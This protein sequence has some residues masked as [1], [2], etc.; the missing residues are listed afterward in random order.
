MHI[1]LMCEPPWDIARE[2]SVEKMYVSG[3]T[4]MVV[5]SA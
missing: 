2:L 5:N 4:F 1:V 3:E